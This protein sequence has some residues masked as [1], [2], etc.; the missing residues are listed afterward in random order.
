MLINLILLF[1]VYKYML[2]NVLIYTYIFFH[3]KHID[4]TYFNV[5]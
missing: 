2:M 5:M 1:I 3:I 4:S